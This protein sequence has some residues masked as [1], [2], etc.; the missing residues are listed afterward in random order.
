MNL[1]IVNDVP[2]RSSAYTIA[3]VA[4]RQYAQRM[5]VASSAHRSAIRCTL[6][7]QVIRYHA[8]EVRVLQTPYSLSISTLL[9]V[10]FTCR[11]DR[12]NSPVGWGLRRQTRCSYYDNT[13]KGDGNVD[14]LAGVGLSRSTVIHSDEA[15]IPAKVVSSNILNY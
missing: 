7:G 6:V 4:P 8:K 1:F 3:L 11:Q 13:R 9:W 10:W 14:A 5:F 2:N 15:T 12:G